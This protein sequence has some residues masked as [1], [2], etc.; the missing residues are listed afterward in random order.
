ML[1]NID[2]TSLVNRKTNAGKKLRLLALAYFKNE[3]NK[4]TN[5]KMLKVIRSNV[6]KSVTLFI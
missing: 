5:Y 4:A 2:F 3:M 6:N 1:K